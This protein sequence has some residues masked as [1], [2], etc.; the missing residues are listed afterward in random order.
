MSFLLEPYRARI[1]EEW[2]IDRLNTLKVES[3]I[4]LGDRNG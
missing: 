4:I 1:I 2:V 3:L